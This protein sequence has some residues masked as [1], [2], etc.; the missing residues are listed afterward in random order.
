VA[1]KVIWTDPAVDDLEAAVEFV[2]RDSA[3]YASALAQQVCD[4]GDS[5]AEFAE[6]GRQLPDPELTDFREVFI[7]SYRLVYS[8]EPE[9]VLIVGII[10]GRRDVST[11]LTGRKKA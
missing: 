4:A 10:H 7:G 5:L 6:R 8:V 3:S 9:R 11:A 2:A 1:R